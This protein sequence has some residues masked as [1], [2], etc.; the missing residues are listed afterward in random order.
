MRYNRICSDNKKFDQRC[1]N[2][3][4]WL[5]ERGCSERMVRTQILKARGESRDN[6]L[7]R[8]I[9][10]TSDSKL[11][12]NITYYP[13]FQNVR[14]ILEELQNLLA[15]NK[16]HKKFFSDV[17]IVGFRNGKSLKDYLVRVVLPQT[18]NAGGSEPCGKGA[19]QECDHIITTNTSTTKACGEVFKIQSGPLNCT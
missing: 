11:T 14:S 10:K 13:A 15:P 1:N 17:P 2:L 12:F 18:D 3:E 4:K 7:E 16:E 6:L 5:M 9:T 8:R 19:C